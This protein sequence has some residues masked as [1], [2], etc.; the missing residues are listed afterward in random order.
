MD[1]VWKELHLSE[2]LSPRSEKKKRIY[3]SSRSLRR[4]L[5]INEVLSQSEYLSVD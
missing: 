1:V 2:R 3:R 5:Q 4:L